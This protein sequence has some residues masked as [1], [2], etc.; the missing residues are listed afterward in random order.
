MARIRRKPVSSA[1]YAGEFPPVFRLASTRSPFLNQAAVR[2]SQEAILED[3]SYSESRV[4][5]GQPAQDESHDRLLETASVTGHREVASNDSA[6]Q[7]TYQT[8]YSG[9]DS[10]LHVEDHYRE[11]DQPAG[12]SGRRVEGLSSVKLGKLWTPFWLRRSTLTAFIALYVLLLLSVTVL[13]RIAQDRNG[14]TPRF[15]TH[16]YTWTYGPTAVLVIVISL[17]R[18]VEYHCKILAPWH[19]LSHG[20]EASKSLLLD[21]VSPSQ[22]TTLWLAIRHGT[23]SVIA[24]IAGFGCLKLTVRIL[25]LL[26]SQ[27]TNCQW[28]LDHLLDW[29]PGVK[30]RAGD[31]LNISS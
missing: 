3:S 12:D 16:H 29:S 8:N 7:S 5:D 19:E 13:W 14:F 30:S 20:A 10:D 28:A 2:I 22:V 23:V 21:Y 11:G 4:Q 6:A 15:P 9:A 1:F 27:C 18:Q 24:A 31:K 26:L 25:G 17:W